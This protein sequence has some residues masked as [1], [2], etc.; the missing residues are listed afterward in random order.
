MTEGVEGGG[1]GEFPEY[2]MTTV[3]SVIKFE[4]TNTLNYAVFWVIT[5]RQAV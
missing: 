4:I 2:Y 1:G 3:K 5:R